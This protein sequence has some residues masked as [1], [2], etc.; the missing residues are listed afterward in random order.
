MRALLWILED[1]WK[2]T[3]DAARETLPGDAEVT[4][5]ACVPEDVEALATGAASGLLGRRRPHPGPE[6]KRISD[7]EAQALVADA[8]ARYGGEVKTLTRRGRV[9]REV[10]QQAADGRADVVVFARD[11]DASAL[12]PRT[13]G[14]AGRFVLDHLPCRMLVVWPEETPSV[15]TLPPM[16]P[17]GPEPPPPGWE[18][19][20]RRP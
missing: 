15:D 1:T 9:E 17:P 3:V 4:I 19:D 20:A 18:D 16:P 8:A 5:L 2:A 11:G 14:R 10:V 12:G 7:Q 13:F 6:L